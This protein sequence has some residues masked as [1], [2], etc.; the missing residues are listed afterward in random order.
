MDRLLLL[1]VPLLGAI[2]LLAV[3]WFGAERRNRNLIV[4]GVV[5][6]LILGFLFRVPDPTFMASPG[7]IKLS[8]DVL[9]T[10]G[11]YG[12][13]NTLLATWVTMLLLLGLAWAATRNLQDVPTGLQ[14]F[15]EVVIEWLW[16]LVNSVTRSRDKS[17]AFF[18]LIATLF[19][20]IIVANWLGLVPGF[21]ALE[22][23]VR[24]P[25]HAEVKPVSGLAAA[26]P[27][28]EVHHVHLFRPA[29][30]DLNTTLALA[31]VS[32]FMSQYW[33]IK[34]LGAGEYRH[35]F[36]TG[37]GG[38]MFTVVGLLELI[39]EIAKLISFS[40]RLFGNIFAGEVLLIIMS[41]LIPFGAAV[42]FLGLEVFIGFIQAA[43][44]AM[45][46]LVFLAGATTAHGH[47]DH[48]AAD[49]AEAAAHH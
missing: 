8:G 16:N 40:F 28:E 25:A 11:G 39:S 43:V 20:F 12:V 47:D 38:P 30:T 26:P 44:F 13:T 15:F 9:F 24:A 32:V 46:T 7:E 14:N 21:T 2:V 33:G 27:A 48:H 35:K 31:L 41:F 1:L 5:G 19:L 23:N 37:R 6:L 18:P 10:I 17:N 49:H 36:F 34:Y 45:L 4:I 22:V 29:T 42:P 3:L